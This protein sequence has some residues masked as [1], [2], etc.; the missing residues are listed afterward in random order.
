MSNE[1]TWEKTQQLLGDKILFMYC[2][3]SLPKTWEI[4][5]TELDSNQTQ[6]R[7][8]EH[9]EKKKI[10]QTQCFMDTIAGVGVRLGCK[11]LI[12]QIFRTRPIFG[13]VS[14]SLVLSLE[15]VSWFFKVIGSSFCPIYSLEKWQ[16]CQIQ[17][18]IRIWCH[19]RKR[20]F[21]KS[22]KELSYLFGTK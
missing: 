1:N 5:L 3:L 21:L 2:R 20:K 6:F 12:Q 10:V 7:R 22:K 14:A 8:R 15:K 17:D 19:I 13:M 4:W 9:R 16:K 11:Y 18:Q